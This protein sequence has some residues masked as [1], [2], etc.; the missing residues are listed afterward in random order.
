MHLADDGAGH[1]VAGSEF[2]R[3]VITLHESFEA[4][5][6]EDSAFS[7][8]R[9]REQKSRRAFHCERGGMKLYE[10]HV[11]EDSACFIGDG[12]AVAGGHFGIGGLAVDL[13]QAAGGQQNCTR[14]QLVLRTVG[15]INEAQPR[16]AAALDDQFGRECVRAQVQMRD[17]VRPSKQRT[18]DFSAGRIAV[19]VQD[20]RAAVRG[21]SCK[22]Q[23]RS[24]AVEFR[25]PCDEL[26]DVLRAFFD[27][28]GYGVRAAQTI[29]GIEGVLFVQS[30]FI[31]VGKGYGDTTLRPGRRRIAQIGFCENQHASRCAQL[32]RRAQTGDA[33]ADHDI[34]G[35]MD[36]VGVAHGSEGI[37]RLRMVARRNSAKAAAGPGMRCEQRVCYIENVARMKTKRI[38]VKS[39]AGS[40]TVVTGSGVIR[41]AAQE[42][43]ALG[44]FSSVHVVSS[45]RVWR[46]AEKAV[47]RGLRL[48]KGKA[49][50][51]FDDAE[52]AKNLRSVEHIARSLCRAGADR[53]SLVVAVGGG[54]VGDVA[55][56]AAAAFLRGV[57]LVHI[58]TTLVAQVDSSIG[59]KTGVNLPEGKNLVGAFYSP[60]LVLT[61]PELLRTLSD[62]EFRGGLAE[63]IKHAIIADAAMFA[64]LEKGMEKVLRRDRRS[65]GFLIPRNVEIKAR[66]VSQDERE[67]GLREILNF[68][69]T[70]AHALETVTKYRV[71]QHGEAVAWGI[72][73]AS[74]LGHELGLTRAEDVSR[75]VAL[76]RRLGPLPPWPRVPAATL[77]AAMRSDKKTRAGILRF[78]LSPRIGEA[79]SYDTVPLH[80]VERVLHFTPRLITASNKL[81]RR[82]HG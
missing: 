49:I 3:F 72:M 42:I 30:D 66:V 63:V 40:Y 56:F 61:D 71:Y 48:S 20:S 67:S 47:Q 80:V 17:G 60:E 51:L 55:G 27:K 75:I 25:A 28:Q 1:D 39:S 13:A 76:I 16:D 22:R 65:L 23:F 18:A 74:F 50:H 34:V 6:A 8:Q 10:L 35:A 81:S 69:H 38:S 26:G 36:F 73:A 5:V 21:L 12:H 79:R 37:C 43:A 11:G 32:D 62:R 77:L 29:A 33:A 54:V 45:P 52:S 19:S 53:L 14:A 46:A 4:D 9:L 70:F 68:G 31:F 57:K 78:V 24:R 59:G 7:A 82:R 41:R 2:L 44:K 64:I 58:P 15:F